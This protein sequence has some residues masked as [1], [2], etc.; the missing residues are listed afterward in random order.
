MLNH[1]NLNNI[2]TLKGLYFL[3]LGGVGEI[4]S[5][6][7]LYCCDNS[8][9]M[10]DLGVSFADEKYPGIDILTPNLSFIDH[11][12]DKIQAL[13]IS[14]AHEDHAGAISYFSDKFP[15]PIYATKFACHLIE[16]KLK[17]YNLSKN[18]KLERI[19]TSKKIKLKNF[20]ISFFETTHSIPEPYAIKISTSYGNILHTAD[21]KIDNNPLIGNSFNKSQFINIGEEGVLALIGDSTNATTKGFS[22]S[23]KDVRNHLTKLFSFYDARIVAT[24]FSSNITRLE[25]IAYAAKL[26]N[27]KVAILG[28]SINRTIE[29]AKDIG[30]LKNIDPFL[31][32]DEC[33][34]IPRENIVIICTGSQGEKRSALYRLAYNSHQNL[35]LEKGDV[36][37]FSSRD[38]PGNEKSIN[39]LKN[40]LIRQNI[41]IITGEDELV[42]VSGH[43]HSEELKNM[44]QWVKPYIAIP[45]HGE[46]IHLAEH[47]K[48][49]Q[50][51]QVPV[52]KILNNGSLL[53]MAPDKPNIIQKIDT[54]KMIVEGKKT[55]N[56]DSD[57]IKARLK[58]SYKGMIMVT[59]LI[60]KDLTI[61]KNISI[62]QFGLP[63]ENTQ[64]L[65]DN[66][67]LNFKEK[68]MIIDNKKKENDDLIRELVK[69][70]I[71][72]ICSEKFNN[73]PEILT[74]LI[75][76]N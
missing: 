4:G 20:N 73:K 37:I 8:W 22:G 44:Y 54:G 19:D 24:C 48:I 59:L 70:V 45:V 76:L 13:I 1:N 62:S 11:I 72:K 60:N 26:N 53:K 68:F 64:L 21:W 51:C 29:V 61:N 9:I 47:A 74:H 27:R 58:Y 52:V 49:A 14:H 5:N 31:S 42:H 15:C 18:I 57:F 43:A 34:L 10:I 46:P 6:C 3:P 38:I 55:Y 75:R 17:D 30:Y 16:K 36:V 7:Y 65:T 25:S 28:K 69:K 23:E 66:F 71:R 63:N 2:E 12:K 40:L 33:H 56:S 32:E 41:D 35:N 50:S 67:K 39:N